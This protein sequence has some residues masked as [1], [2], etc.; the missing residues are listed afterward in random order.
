M[1]SPGMEGEFAREFF[2]PEKSAGKP[3]ITGIFGIFV[4]TSY[5]IHYTKLYDVDMAETTV[6]VTAVRN[7]FV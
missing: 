3:E 6:L 4:I 1:A 7:N 5:S 2:G